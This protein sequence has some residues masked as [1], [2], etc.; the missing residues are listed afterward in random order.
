MLY[1]PIN[2]KANP[3][4]DIRIARPLSL[5]SLYASASMPIPEKPK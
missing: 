2:P 3:V 1:I 5:L 4:N